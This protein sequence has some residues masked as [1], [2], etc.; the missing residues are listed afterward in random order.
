MDIILFIL[1]A[2]GAVGGIIWLIKSVG[3][4]YRRWKS[5]RLLAT[6]PSDF[7]YKDLE[8]AARISDRGTSWYVV[9]Q[10]TAKI[11]CDSLDHLDMGFNLVD[12]QSNSCSVSP[13]T[14]RLLQPVK[15]GGYDR[16]TIKLPAPLPK[17]A[18]TEFR[19]TVDFKKQFVPN[20]PR[21]WLAWESS[22][23][24]DSLCLRVV[25]FGWNPTGAW[26]V[27]RDL[28]HRVLQEREIRP[29]MISHE[30]R[31]NVNSPATNLR[32]AIEWELPMDNE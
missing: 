7:A 18:E 31:Y 21:D 1:T 29:D 11:L 22:R 17:G 12:S 20:T 10:A 3:G 14:L 2:F 28:S 19:L 15:S 27:V 30:V 4:R 16:I 32:Y 24:V 6:V 26:T 9:R 5:R 13:D 8:I 25:F 23:E